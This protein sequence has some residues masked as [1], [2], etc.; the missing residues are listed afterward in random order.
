MKILTHFLARNR[1]KE[2]K[3]EQNL[4]FSSFKSLNFFKRATS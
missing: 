4:Y 1:S 3:I 2:L